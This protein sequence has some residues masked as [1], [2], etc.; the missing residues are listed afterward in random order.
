MREQFLLERFAAEKQMRVSIQLAPNLKELFKL[1]K[2]GKVDVIF[3]NLTITEQRKKNM[4]FSF[5]VAKSKVSIVTSTKNHGSGLQMLLNENVFVID[6][7]S[8]IEN[9]FVL[10]KKLGKMRIVRAPS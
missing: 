3:D 6:N 7:S 2:T 4:L 5:P 10:R 8:H 9:L 1:L